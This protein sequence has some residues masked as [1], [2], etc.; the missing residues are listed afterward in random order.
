MKRVYLAD[1]HSDERS[2]L[3][4]LLVEMNLKVVGEATDWSTALIQAPATR[5]DMI[6][7]DWGLVAAGSGTSLIELRQAC[8]TAVVIVLIS[9]LEAREQAA[10]SVG[11][12]TFISKGETSER[13]V[14][15]LQAAVGNLRS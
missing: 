1:A 3:R 9:H 12:D 7:V 4:L 10:I 14:E 11:A 2:A 6:L 5:P 15:R 8:R 13:V